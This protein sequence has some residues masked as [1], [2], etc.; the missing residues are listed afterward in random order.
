MQVAG[1]QPGRA[2]RSDAVLQ[3]LGHGHKAQRGVLGC[4]KQISLADTVAENKSWSQLLEQPQFGQGLDCSSPIG[5]QAGVGQSQLGE[6][7]PAQHRALSVHQA[8]AFAPKY[9]ASN[10]VGKA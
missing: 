1:H 4:N 9:Q 5:R 7:A 8:W 2:R 6:I 10:G 3:H